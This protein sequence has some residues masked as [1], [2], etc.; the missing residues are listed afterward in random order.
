M[1]KLI[2][3]DSSG[4]PCIAGID[5]GSNLSG[6]T[7]A[8]INENNKFNFYFSKKGSNT[9][10]WLFKLLVEKQPAL[11]GIDAPLSLPG[12]YQGLDMADY[13]YRDCD[14]LMKAMS[15]MF[16]GGLTARSIKLKDQLSNLNIPVYEVYPGGYISDN[17]LPVLKKNHKKDEFLEYKQSLGVDID[18]V[19]NAHALDALIAWIIS[20][21]IFNKEAKSIGNRL[22]GLIYV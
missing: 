19:I 15:P 5:F 10:I 7:V 6:N 8:C 22:E 12:V 9:D 21:R 20:V 17:D 11:V 2:I 18:Q 16:I 13:F 4:F 1:A 3:P 14:R